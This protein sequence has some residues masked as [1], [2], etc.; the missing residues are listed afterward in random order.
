[1]TFNKIRAALS[2][3]GSTTRS[4][5][6]FA[7][8]DK[9]DFIPDGLSNV[10]NNINYMGVQGQNNV[11]ANAIQKV[12]QDIVSGLQRDV[13]KFE[14][15]RRTNEIKE[16]EGIQLGLWTDFERYVFDNP[17]LSAAEQLKQT[18]LKATE[19][20]GKVK[21]LYVER[22]GT[23]KGT[24]L[25]D[26]YYSGRGTGNNAR[27]VASI[28]DTRRLRI[29]QENEVSSLNFVKNHNNQLND[30]Y[31]SIQYSNLGADGFLEKERQVIRNYTNYWINQSGQNKS[32]SSKV[33]LSDEIGKI[34]S[35][36]NKVILTEGSE[37]PNRVLADGTS[38]PNYIEIAN[39]WTEKIDKRKKMPSRQIKIQNQIFDPLSKF[40]N[41]TWAQ[42]PFLDLDLQLDN[43]DGTFST[44]RTTT[45]TVDLDGDGVATDVLLIPTIRK[46][47]GKLVEFNIDEAEEIA[48]E[49][50]DYIIMEGKDEAEK[51][52]NGDNL[53]KEISDGIDE[54][55]K[56]SQ[57]IKIK[58]GGKKI[59]LQEVELFISE[60]HELAK[61]VSEQNQNFISINNVNVTSDFYDYINRKKAKDED[62]TAQD[63]EKRLYT[64]GSD[65]KKVSKL[66][67][68][69]A[70]ALTQELI[71]AALREPVKFDTLRNDGIV[72]DIIIKGDVIKNAYTK[73][74][75]PDE[76]DD[77]NTLYINES[78]GL[79]LLERENHKNPIYSISSEIVNKYIKES[80]GGKGDRVKRK[81]EGSFYPRFE[82]QINAAYTTFG[83]QYKADGS[84][85]NFS[86]MQG[87]DVALFLERYKD[88]LYAEYEAKVKSGISEDDLNNSLKSNFF[89]DLKKRDDFPSKKDLNKIRTDGRDRD[90][91]IAMDKAKLKI[92]KET[93]KLSGETPAEYLERTSKD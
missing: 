54:A 62:I 6:N 74:S 25:Y 83:G 9:E 78:L 8:T 80:K 21:A 49:N 71:K 60:N 87:Y 86:L 66:K 76:K 52:L 15:V 14:N 12:G 75:L 7:T 44:L 11:Q 45:I 38:V 17:A 41:K 18:D 37:V 39:Y 47:D 19:I 59:S 63:L 92:K 88:K 85:T 43:G 28:E 56:A 77:I 1:M 89:W 57:N 67:G 29:I 50:K 23:E 3:V 73:F 5:E 46:I 93:Q 13:E 72:N 26:N 4:R 30:N 33:L 79:S 24:F 27:A 34:Q 2:K 64:T 16:F 10:V 61:K 58:V 36:Y 91:K 69:A 31:L 65:N 40:K 20:L 48:L 32:F 42:R 84:S 82:N 35:A 55:R 53:S 81:Y 90:R 51:I 22:H 70:D 68:K